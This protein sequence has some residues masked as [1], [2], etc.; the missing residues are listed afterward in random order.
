MDTKQHASS[1]K[2]YIAT[3]ETPNPITWKRTCWTWCA[4]FHAWVESRSSCL[5]CPLTRGKLESV[6]VID[7]SV[8]QVELTWET[9]S[10]DFYW[11]VCLIIIISWPRSSHVRLWLCACSLIEGRG[12]LADSQPWAINHWGIRRDCA[13]LYWSCWS[14]V[15]LTEGHE[16]LSVTKTEWSVLKTCEI[17]ELGKFGCWPQCC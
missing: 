2:R 17:E 1:A 6:R 4:L 5:V 16:L 7:V 15:V 11:N 12:L 14:L 10:W 9:R 8:H 13:S 3:T